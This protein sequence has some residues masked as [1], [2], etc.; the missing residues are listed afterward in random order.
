MKRVTSLLFYLEDEPDSATLQ[1]AAKIADSAGATLTL[2]ATVEPAALYPRFAMGGLDIDEIEGLLIEDRQRRLEESAE[3]IRT[4]S[5]E[6]MTRVFVGDAVEVVIAVVQDEG[7]DLVVKSPS[8]SQGIRKQLF[9]SIDMHLMRTCPCPVLIGR[10]KQDGY[11]GH[12]VAAVSYDAGDNKYA[13]LNKGILESA[14]WV[15]E[16]QF[17]AINEIHVV[18]AWQ[19]YGESLLAH[20]RGKL[21]SDK[22]QEALRQEEDKR[23]QWLTNLIDEFQTRMP[24]EAEV[25]FKPVLSLLHGDPKIVIPRLVKELDADVLSLGT[26]SRRGV[27]GLLIGNTAEEILNRVSCSVVTHRLA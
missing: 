14:A 20:G 23:E 25:R 1:R 2:A 8:P 5:L 11:S 15:A 3:L 13:R 22:F 4:P 16:T 6:I 26:V 19:L 27:E 24:K 18:H 17:A 10:A 9:G 21:P 7:F 12:A